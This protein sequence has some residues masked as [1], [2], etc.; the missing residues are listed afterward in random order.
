MSLFVIS[1]A[2]DNSK[3]SAAISITALLVSGAVS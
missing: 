3:I 2:G 1:L